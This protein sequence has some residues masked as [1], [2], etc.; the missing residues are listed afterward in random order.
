MVRGDI[1]GKEDVPERKEKKA[2]QG[3]QD[4][5]GIVL[6]VPQDLQ[7]KE[8]LVLDLPDP[9]DLREAGALLGVKVFRGYK[10]FK[11]PPDPRDLRGRKE[12]KVYRVPQAHKDSRAPK[13]RREI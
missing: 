8:L 11:V 7:D 1:K 13:D 9:Q 3:P 2:P 12:I 5:Q 4:L 6:L 10:V